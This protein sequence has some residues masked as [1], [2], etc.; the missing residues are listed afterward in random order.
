MLPGPTPKVHLNRLHWWQLGWRHRKSRICLIK[1]N[2]IQCV[3]PL[4]QAFLGFALIYLIVPVPL[5]P[6]H[7]V[8]LQEGNKRLLRWFTWQHTPWNTDLTVIRDCM[9]L[10]I[11]YLVYLVYIYIHMKYS[12]YGNGRHQELG[13]LWQFSRYQNP[14]S[15]K[16]RH[17][18]V[19]APFLT[20]IDSADGARLPSILQE[21]VTKVSSLGSASQAANRTSKGSV[22]SKWFRNCQFYLYFWDMLPNIVRNGCMAHTTNGLRLKLCNSQRSWG[23]LFQVTSGHLIHFEY[24][25]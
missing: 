23:S 13:T 22:L 12:I 25:I 11:V 5:G 7:V 21:L 8:S 1:L 10:F 20:F 15:G 4:S 6:N 9:I 16:C 2:V 18:D 24:C 3:I 17:L 19:V 14:K